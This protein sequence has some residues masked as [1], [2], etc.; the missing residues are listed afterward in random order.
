[1]PNERIIPVEGSSD[2]VTIKINIEGAEVPGTYQPL[3]IVVLKEVNRVPFAKVALLDGEASG[4]NFAASSDEFFIPGK[5]IEILAGYDE[6]EDVIFKGII[7][8]HGIQIRQDGTSLLKLDCRDK[9]F[10]TTLGLKNRYFTSMTDGDAIQQIMSAYDVSSSINDFEVNHSEL[11]QFESSDWDFIITRTEANGLICIADDGIINIQKP[12]FDQESLLTLQFGATILEFDGE[13]DARNQ[14]S[15]IKASG[16]DY[17]S[18]EMIEAEATEPDGIPE[19]G[20][21][22]GA[23]LAGVGA[24]ESYSLRHSG[25]VVQDELQT[26]ADSEMLKSRLSKN[27]GRVKFTGFASL[28]PGNLIALQGLGDRFNGTVFV[29][30]VRHDIVGG[31]WHTQVQFGFSHDWISNKATAGGKPAGNLIPS[32]PGLHIGVV[33]QLQDDP[34]GEHRILVK[35]PVVDPTAE[36]TW[37]RIATLDAGEN[38]GSFFLPE[39]GDEVIV[40]FIYDD[41]RDAVI[42]GML[43]SSAK[44]APL[45]ASDDNFEKGFITKTG[46]KIL[47]NDETKT[48]TMETPTGKKIVLDEDEGAIKLEDENGNSIIMDSNGITIESGTDLILKAGSNLQVEGGANTEIKAGASFKAEGSAGAEVSTSAVAVL[49]GSLV[50]IN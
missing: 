12:D 28:K 4:E 46:M 33:T 11:I 9:V 38:R 37:A 7:V 21:L 13:I 25:Q 42:L 36:G 1:M 18:Q 19:A 32:I 10:K 40:G 44:P 43:N 48:L 20:N 50:Q 47:F 34:D 15:A 29:S 22:S 30:G 8:K 17:S 39:I 14:F 23:D 6:Q 16:W 31:E 24:L 2:K 5:E 49:K 35:L 26:W 27:R 41:P 45:E 3:S